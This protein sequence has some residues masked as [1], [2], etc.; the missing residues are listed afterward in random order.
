[1]AAV[2]LA[3][4]EPAPEPQDQPEP[5]TFRTEATC[6]RFDVF[7]TS[8]GRPVNRD[9]HG[10]WLMLIVDAPLSTPGAGDYLVEA[11]Y[12]LNGTEHRVQTPVRVTR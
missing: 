9:P 4:R 8:D 6:I 5:R 10:T 3:A 1:M 2:G 12:V 11:G 7:P